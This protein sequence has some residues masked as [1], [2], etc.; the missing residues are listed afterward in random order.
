M[1][2]RT[3]PEWDSDSY[4]EPYDQ[5]EHAWTPEHYD[6]SNETHWVGV[7]AVNGYKI[8]ITADDADSF[9]QRRRRTY[10]EWDSDSYLEPYNQSEHAWTHEQYD[11][12]NETHWVDVSA[13]DG[14]KIPI[15]ADDANSLVQRQ[16]KLLVSESA[17]SQVAHKIKGENDYNW[18]CDVRG[19]DGLPFYIHSYDEY[20]HCAVLGRVNTNDILYEAPSFAQIPISKQALA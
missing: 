16:S 4:L 14:Y 15:T 8:P 1:A 13:V 10:P 9:V 3:Y 18:L 19:E 17:L 6:M 2:R 7:S 12:S 11:M 20:Y 5:S